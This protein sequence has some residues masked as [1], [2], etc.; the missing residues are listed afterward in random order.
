MSGGS[1]DLDHMYI[2]SSGAGSFTQSNGD[3]YMT[4]EFDGM[5]LG[6]NVGGMG[7]YNL[8]GGSLSVYDLD[9]GG[10]G[11]GVFNWTGGTLNAKHINIVGA[12]SY[13]TAAGDLT[14]AG[15]VSVKSGADLDMVTTS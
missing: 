14:L 7:T 10:D 3:V 2:G 4:G 15:H 9:V 1:F 5:D 12:A 6:R 13:M 11:T 8:N